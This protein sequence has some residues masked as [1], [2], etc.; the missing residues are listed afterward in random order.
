VWRRVAARAEGERGQTTFCAA[1]D[2]DHPSFLRKKRGLCPEPGA[3][4][5]NVVCPPEG[6]LS[7]PEGGRPTLQPVVRR[8]ADLPS[9][10]TPTSISHPAA[11]SGT[12]SGP[13][14]RLVTV[15]V[16]SPLLLTQPKLRTERREAQPVGEVE[17]RAE[18]GVRF[19]YSPFPLP[20]SRKRAV[21]GSHLDADAG[22]LALMGH[23]QHRDFSSGAEPAV[24][25]MATTRFTVEQGGFCVSSAAN[26]A[27]A[28]TAAGEFLRRRARKTR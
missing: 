28:A 24:D 27:V 13:P 8:R 26:P 23:R 25:S 10:P 11:G 7:P 6:G 19:I 1:L 22:V 5:Q 16:K 4:D 9:S 18:K 17:P 15:T 3:G 12:G 20:L 14:E 21:S 2:G